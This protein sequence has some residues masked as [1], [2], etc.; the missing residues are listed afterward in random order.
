MKTKIN[1]SNTAA[2]LFMALCMVIGLAW[3]PSNQQATAHPHDKTAPSTF[4]RDAMEDM[5]ELDARFMYAA[6]FEDELDEFELFQGQID[7]VQSLLDV[8]DQVAEIAKKP[9]L[10]AVAAVMAAEDYFDEP[11]EYAAFL[12]GVL[13]ETKD[14]TVRRAIYLRLAD[15]YKETDQRD[16]GL[17][18]L[19]KLIHDK[20]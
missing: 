20:P 15:T 13:P 16:K 10:S 14:P 19:K 2:L 12:N 4:Y 8:V 5:D 1:K 17:V 7:L 3:L 18:Y 9:S 6:D 11:E